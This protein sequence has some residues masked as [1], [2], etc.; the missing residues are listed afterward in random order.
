MD[1][2]G[3]KLGALFESLFGDMWEWIVTPFKNLP[4]FKNLI[5]GRD[6]D[7]DLAYGIFKTDEITNIFGPGVKVF[8]TLAIF[9]I[10]IGIILGGM[11]VS[12]TGINPSNRTYV[13]DFFKD[14]IIVGLVLFNLDTLYYIMFGLNYSII[15]VFGAAHEEL[16]ELKDSIETGKGVIGWLIINLCLLGLTIWANFYYMMRKLTLLL[17][18]IMGPLMVTLYLIPKT[19][20]IT[21]A[22]LKE[23]FGTVMV[24]SI[25][26]MLY[27]AI[28][29]LSASTTGVESVIL[30]VIFIPVSEA[31]RALFGL[32]G[33][34][35]ERLNRAAAMMGGGAL[36]GIYGAFK[37]ALGEKSVMETIKGAYRG[38]KNN[39]NVGDS[40]SKEEKSKGVLNNVGTDVSSTAKSERML[41]SGE[42]MSK[43]GKAI[44][45]AAG[46]I[47]G[48]P[49]GPMGSIVGS[50]IGFGMGGVVG[51][52]IG[53]A[54]AAVTQGVAN[55]L[56]SGFKEGSKKF[57][58]IQNAEDEADE[59]LAQTIAE[60][61]TTQWASQN[62]ELFMKDL[63]ERFPDA[64]DS[65]LSQMW[66]NE[67]NAKR[68]EFLEKARNTVGQINRG[69]QPHARAEDLVNS[70]VDSLTNDWAERNKENFNTAYDQQNPLPANATADDIAKHNKQKEKAWQNTIANKRNEIRQSANNTLSKIGGTS[71]VV[72]VD[73]FAKDVGQELEMLGLDP[74]KSTKLI[75][76][77]IGSTGDRNMADAK[78]LVDTTVDTLTT[79]WAKN[80]KDAFMADYDQKNP[81]PANASEEMIANHNQNRATAWQNAVNNKREA[82]QRTAENTATKF[83]N[84]ANTSDQLI[85]KEQFIEQMGQEITSKMNMSSSQANS[86]IK[87]AVNNVPSTN[88]QP[89][90]TSELVN[91][92]VDK[93]TNTWAK[94]NQEKFL[95]NYDKS[96]PLPEN[97][98]STVIQQHNQNRSAAWQNAVANKRQEISGVVNQV[99]SKLSYNAPNPISFVDKEA[100]ANEVGTSVADVLGKGSRETVQAVKQATSSVK[101]VSLYS[102]KSVN[103][104]ML[105]NRLAEQKTSAGM[106]QYINDGINSG[107]FQT[108]EEGL[109]QWHQVEAPKR[110]NENV[111]E[112]ASSLPRMIPLNHRV[113]KNPVARAVGASVIA[114]SSFVTGASGI[115]EISQFVG[116]SRVGQASKLGMMAIQEEIS[117][118]ANYAQGVLSG[119]QEKGISILQEGVNQFVSGYQNYTPVNA[120]EKQA[121]FRNAVAYTVG[122]IGGVNGY[123][124]GA[125]LGMKMNPYNKAVNE[126]TAEMADIQHM[127]Q[128]VTDD[129]GTKIPN[130]AIRI[131]TTANQTVLQVRNKTGQVQTVSRIS[132]GDSSLKKGETI[133]QDLSIDNGHL[134]PV[135]PVYKEDS[136]GGRIS[137]N[138][139]INID[140]NK[141]VANRNTPQSPRIVN[142][143]QSYNQAVDSGQYYLRDAIKDMTNIQMIVDRNRSYLVGQKDGRQYRI[144]QYGPGDARLT[145]NEVIYRTCDVKNT[146]LEIKGT[147]KQIDN[148]IFD[149]NDYTTTLTP[150]D[151]IPRMPPNKRNMARKQSEKYREKSLTEP[152]R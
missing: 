101:P 67:V 114:A 57:K 35:H 148:E 112:L 51:G 87:K 59:K 53:R 142:E 107:Q 85:N 149:Y 5:F 86:I 140:P 71:S 100:F 31:I 74:D 137:L 73:A 61:E 97:A 119:I 106:T 129:T 131:V 34:M 92:T 58:G 110:F 47:T 147:Q 27:W 134:S 26:A 117:K 22:W 113:I 69:N 105:L 54:G 19:K 65:Q 151:L 50:T 1:V 132:T 6:G 32:G 143:V 3:D 95:N 78:K 28:A 21:W 76:N 99:A 20:G 64:S 127:V 39:K 63:K 7:G 135:S 81:L 46:A 11:K 120:V 2:L 37:G 60:D 14:L 77:T 138:R 109:Q 102:G 42:I 70:T 62:K 98:S 123:K 80:N 8:M 124:K 17:L 128:T 145:P 104:E 55:R 146:R 108:Q 45:G 121:G 125:K 111:S 136:G 10:L 150:N 48:S 38:F 116:E 82:I 23:L 66:G 144:S 90:K 72:D 91:S 83:T 36:T 89:A 133:Y 152:L 139:S 52:T 13:L 88:Q 44:V 126:Q 15:N 25:H 24:Q 75:K 56:N 43:A 30:Y 33:D 93:L 68:G 122:V 118:P 130:G 49:M 18:M 84:G 40:E 12:S 103:R 96:N 79:N 115:K 94:D 16:F 4:T 41:K 9:A 29:L 141:L